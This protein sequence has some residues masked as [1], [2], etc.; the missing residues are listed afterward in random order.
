MS[1]GMTIDLSEQDHHWWREV[2]VRQ[3]GGNPYLNNYTTVNYNNEPGEKAFEYM[4][5]LMTKHK[6]T[7]PRFMDEGQ[8]AFKSGRAAMH[9][10]GSF[11]L[12]SFNKA[13]RLDWGVA[14][15]PEHNGMRSNFSSYWVNAVSKKAQGEK[16][17]AAEKFIQFITS[18]AAMPNLA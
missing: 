3:M 14:E 10:D 9:I 1:A 15:L 8:A 13:R 17:E 7:D 16:K 4:T 18:E 5:D 6:V 12:A 2:L 11:R